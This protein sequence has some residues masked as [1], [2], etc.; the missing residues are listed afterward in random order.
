[1]TTTKLVPSSP[2]VDT[3]IDLLAQ[4]GLTPIK[5]WSQPNG[6]PQLQFEFKVGTNT[7]R[8]RLQRDGQASEIYLFVKRYEFVDR[9]GQER[10][11]WDAV[12]DFGN[13]LF[14]AEGL[15]SIPVKVGD[16][17]L[18]IDLAEFRQWCVHVRVGEI[19]D[20]S[21][22]HTLI[23]LVIDK[24]NGHDVDGIILDRIQDL[25]LQFS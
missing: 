13:L 19:G 1:M 2:T 14:A 16:F 24:L 3:A 20:V 9:C 4:L 21:Y 25:D 11:G 10:I 5:I 17:L 6:E 7:L 18:R 12:Y 15:V 8:W 23:A 22:D